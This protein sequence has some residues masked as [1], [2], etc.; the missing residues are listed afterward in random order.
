MLDAAMASARQ[1]Q[2]DPCPC[3]RYSTTLA[4]VGGTVRAGGSGTQ[5]NQVQEHITSCEHALS[6]FSTCGDQST[7][8]HDLVRDP[9]QLNM[10]TTEE[11]HSNGENE[12]KLS[13]QGGGECD[14]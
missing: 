7:S 10:E 8:W 12:G 3:R 13:T 5:G 2:Y 4:L 6:A 9:D 1:V 11:T 14:W